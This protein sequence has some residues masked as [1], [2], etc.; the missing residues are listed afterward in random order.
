MAV[1]DVVNNNGTGTAPA[2]A[3]TGDMI[4]VSSGN[5]YQIVDPGTPGANYNPA[6]GRWSIPVSSVVD[7]GLLGLASRVTD[8][9]TGKAQASADK[10]MQ[11]QTESNA[12]AMAFSAEQADKNRVWQE[13]MSN[14]AHQ[15]EVKDLLAAGL[16]PVLS[17]MSGNGATTPSGAS[18]SGVSSSGAQAPVDTSTLNFLASMINTITNRDVNMASLQNAKDIAEIQRGTA[19]DTAAINAK[20]AA[21]VAGIQ[22]SMQKFLAENYPQTMYGTLSSIY[23]GITSGDSNTAKLAGSVG[24]GI[25]WLSGK[26]LKYG[27]AFVDSFKK[28]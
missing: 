20:S 16:N 8:F 27:G 19:L 5:M 25:D 10:M 17:A 14:T 7:N 12:K 24:K 3:Q 6:S 26:I 21:N 4:R 28:H 11:Y 15:R 1:L 22:T 23:N 18:A 13:R 2:S 9:N